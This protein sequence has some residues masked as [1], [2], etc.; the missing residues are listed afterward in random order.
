MDGFWS[1]ATLVANYLFP[2]PR[3]RQRAISRPCGWRRSGGL[4]TV[5]GRLTVLGEASGGRK[6]RCGV[7]H[8][9][10]AR[11]GRRTMPA[12][13]SL[14]FVSTRRFGLS[15]AVLRVGLGRVRQFS[16]RRVGRR[17]D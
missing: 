2:D 15:A 10:G 7:V 9:H 8:C 13:T 5:A 16:K 6:E 17:V 3:F 14:L 11:T 4:S 12:A 1:G